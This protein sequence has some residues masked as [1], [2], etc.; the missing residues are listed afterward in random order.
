MFNRWEFTT[1][2]DVASVLD[3]TLALRRRIECGELRG[4]RISWSESRF[5]RLSRC[6][7]AC[8]A[9]LPKM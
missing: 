7:S 9:E 3:N 5:G 1:V 4:P 6:R 2:F 8:L